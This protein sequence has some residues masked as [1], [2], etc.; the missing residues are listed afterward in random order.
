MANAGQAL[1]KLLSELGESSQFVASGSLTPVLPGLDV[2][3]IGAIG[4]PVSVA[5][6]KR[7]IAQAAL[8]PYGRGEDTILDA[9]VR[10]VWQIEPSKI[11]FRN[12]EWQ[13]HLAM[14]VDAVA[15][16]FGIHQKVHA[17]LYKLLIYDKGSFFAPHRDT[18]KTPG[19]FATLVVCLPS[20]HEG[21]TL[22]VEHDGQTK[23]M[24]FGGKNSEFKTQYAAFYADCRHE[25][26]PVK[27][28]YRICLVY[29]LAL[30]GNKRQPSAPQHAT[31]VEKAARLLEEFFSDTSSTPSKIAIPLQHQ[32]TED[33]LDPGQL[34]GSDRAC[35]DVL[36]RAA[37]S[38]DYQCYLALLTHYQS[39]D[40]DYSTLDFDP[41]ARRRSYRWSSYDDD[42]DEDEEDA[43][44]AGDEADMGEVYE[45]EVSL[46]HWLDPQGKKQPF[47]KM[48]ID[49]EEILGLDD[50]DGWSY[51]QEV[52]EAT[53]NEGVSMERWYR[54]A[55]MVIWPRDRYFRILAEEGPASGVP[56]LRQLAARSKKTAAVEECRQLAKQLIDHWQPDHENAANAASY[57]GLMLETLERIGTQELAGRFVREVLPTDFNGSEGK[58][59][60][61]LCQRFGW[62]HF[63]DALRYFISQQKPDNYH[64][65]LEHVVA[66]CEALCCEPPALTAERHGACA[67]LADEL[68]QLFQRWDKKRQDAWYGRDKKRTGVV[69]NVV[70]VLGTLS[71]VEHLDRFV[72]HTLAD[73]ERYDLRDVLIPAVRTLYRGLGKLAA[74]Q[75]AAARLLQH[76]LGELRQATAQPVEPPKDWTRDAKLKC[77]CEHC[78][79]LSQFLR[80]PAQ[81][82]ARFPLRQ[83]L[84]RHLHGQIDSQGCDLTHV[85]ERKGSPQTLV[86]TKTNASY[87]RRLKQYEVDQKLLAE[88]QTFAGEGKRAIARAPRRRSVKTT[89]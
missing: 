55:V 73:P 68:L 3:E 44:G 62:Q 74:A 85:T 89:P 37:E 31:A 47:G 18:E 25:I 56:A 20:P 67:G 66:I 23:K 39:G 1:E 52:H 80:D 42:E 30:A 59:L 61:R 28:G 27:S 82:V 79:A 69:A 76:C 8:A 9:N 32:Y 7:L 78:R 29:N 70:R 87:E 40:V 10:R 84:R 36:V 13:A 34:K 17:Q 54:Q 86:C 49:P 35:A 6:A 24:E 53:G 60:Q 65:Q 33:G 46:E 5:D 16:A 48:H 2:K 88:L 15:Q 41:Y 57:S 81:R 51:R 14:I 38:L 11:S 19:M 77:Q 83:E 71:A 45:E 12:S 50:K 63:A 26:K 21:G 4:S 43:E 72:A 22:I 75:P 64:T 58:A